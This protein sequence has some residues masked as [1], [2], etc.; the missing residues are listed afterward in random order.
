MKRNWIID[1]ISHIG[2][3]YIGEAMM[4]ASP[5]TQQYQEP[6]QSLLTAEDYITDTLANGGWRCSF[7]FAIRPIL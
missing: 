5:N 6:G 4:E 3:T 7:I 2:R 1:M